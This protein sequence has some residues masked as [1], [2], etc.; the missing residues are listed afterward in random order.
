MFGFDGPKQTTHR[1]PTNCNASACKHTLKDN[2]DSLCD[3]CYGEFFVPGR[4]PALAR[5]AFLRPVWRSL[6]RGTLHCGGEPLEAFAPSGVS[7]ERGGHHGAA[8]AQ[9][10]TLAAL[11]PDL[12]AFYCNSLTTPIKHV[13][14]STAHRW[15]FACPRVHCTPCTKHLLAQLWQFCQSIS[16]AACR[17]LCSWHPRWRRLRPPCRRLCLLNPPPYR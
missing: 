1:L 2:P 10:A 13:R 4:M 15:P 14:G 12:F 11:L 16:N 5:A 9:A 7:G 8:I 3:V 6:P 17:T